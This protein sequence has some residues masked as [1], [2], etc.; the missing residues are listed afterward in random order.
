MRI[1][2]GEYMSS[3][4]LGMWQSGLLQNLLKVANLINEA[5]GSNP[6]VPARVRLLLTNVLPHER[7]VLTHTGI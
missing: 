3:F 4:K 1:I 2:D 6:A 7:S 5:S